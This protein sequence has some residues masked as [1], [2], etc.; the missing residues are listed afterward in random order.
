MSSPTHT[1]INGNA[2]IDIALE[3]REWEARMLSSVWE[4]QRWLVERRIAIV[5]SAVQALSQAR[6]S[7]EHKENAKRAAHTLAGSLGIFGFED[8]C[9]AAALLERGLEHPVDADAP[10]LAALARRLRD[11]TG[12]D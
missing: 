3:D 7:R 6:L 12:L 9:R 5:E 2:P 8:A 10:R 1:P 11:R 4:R